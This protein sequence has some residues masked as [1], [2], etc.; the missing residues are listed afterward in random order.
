MGVSL[1]T[2]DFLH[3]VFANNYRRNGKYYHYDLFENNLN[4]RTK[5]YDAPYSHESL[6]V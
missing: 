2:I 5:R 3:L 6:I 4:F 1:S